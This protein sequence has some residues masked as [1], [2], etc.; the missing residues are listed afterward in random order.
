MNFG[1]LKQMAFEHEELWDMANE[2]I[3]W[4]EKLEGEQAVQKQIH[5]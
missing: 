2:R 5:E 3:T 4:H 1:R